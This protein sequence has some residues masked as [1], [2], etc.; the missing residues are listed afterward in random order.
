MHL[1]IIIAAYNEERRLP[2]TLD[3]MLAYL[4]HHFHAPYEILIIDDGSS[5]RTAE[6]VEAYGQK[7][8]QIRLLRQRPNQGRGAA[9]RAGVRHACGELILETDADGSV[10]NEAIPRFVEH[11]RR[12]P[13]IDVLIGSR[14]MESS[15]ILTPQPF[16]RVFLGY[17]FLYLAKALFGWRI[18]DYTLGF[19]IFRR[20]AALDIYEHQFDDH[21]LAEAELVY[22]ARRRGWRLQ[23]SSVLWTDFR[24]SRVKPI[25][26]SISSFFGLAAVLA[27]ARR[28]QYTNGLTRETF[29]AAAR[30]V[31][32]LYD[33]SGGWTALFNRI[34]FFTAPYSQIEPYV[35][36]KGFVLDLGCGYG[37]FTNLLAAL[38]SER[39]LLGLDLDVEKIKHAHRGLPNARFQSADVTQAPMEPA[40]CIL[41]IHV[42]HHLGSYDEQRLLLMECVKR[43]KP[44][45][46]LIICEVDR[47]PLWKL[48]LGRVADGLLYPG[49]PVFYR[50]EKNMAAFLK[51]AGLFIEVQRMHSGTPFSHI[52]YIASTGSA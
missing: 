49:Q 21:F 11:M 15:Q 16:L 48:F 45:G 50:Y 28:G 31:K 46:R 43:L 26:D 52:T 47:V 1:S 30:R 23:E 39:R 19:K 24:E 14:N 44:S 13:S 9:M 4:A 22:V 5:D 17:C 35:P 8:P 12:H 29:D 2:R 3:Q 37:A 25:S 40:D 51:Q 18:H 42:L 33:K 6:I 10:D 32:S 41:L 27:R 34:R 20:Q 36:R 7:H 38:S